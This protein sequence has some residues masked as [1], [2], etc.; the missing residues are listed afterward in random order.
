[1]A[2]CPTYPTKKNACPSFK[3]PHLHFL[4]LKPT[5]NCL[6]KVLFNVLRDFNAVG[7]LAHPSASVC[8]S[9][10]WFITNADIARYWHC[11]RLAFYYLHKKNLSTSKQASTLK[12]CCLPSHRANRDSWG[13]S[14][15]QSKKWFSMWFFKTRSTFFCF[16]HHYS[17]D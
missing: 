7:Q 4:W 8:G 16:F 14:G 9:A 5:K 15:Q 17:I 2:F 3:Y 6:A 12:I 1:M 10:G 13:K 11:C